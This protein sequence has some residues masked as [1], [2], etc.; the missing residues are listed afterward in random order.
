MFQLQT[1]P[2]RNSMSTYLQGVK[3][4]TIYFVTAIINYEDKGS[5]EKRETTRKK[6][7]NINSHPTMFVD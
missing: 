6:N 2:T 7:T 5:K 1:F 4:D 3:F